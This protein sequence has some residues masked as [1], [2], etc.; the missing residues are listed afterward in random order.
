VAKRKTASSANEAILCATQPG[1]AVQVCIKRSKRGR[2]TEDPV[3]NSESACRALRFLANKDR[4]SFVALHLGAQKQVIGVE[5][6]AVGTLT[7]VLAHPREVFKGAMLSN[8]AS[9]LVAHNHPSGET[10]PSPDDR[11][12]T[13]RLVAAGKLLGI[14]VDDHIIVGA[15]D[16]VS[17]LKQNPEDFE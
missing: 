15:N 10:V 3:L 12:L 6:V 1:R 13:Q 7:S 16:C 17:M 5:E 11:A 9:I 4:E 14:S 8:A 2:L